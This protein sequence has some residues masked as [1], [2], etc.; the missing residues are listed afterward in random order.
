VPGDVVK[1]AVCDV[2]IVQTSALDEERMFG[3]EQAAAGT[4]GSG[5]VAGPDPGGRSPTR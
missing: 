3:Q 1:N 4:D 5:S 2:L